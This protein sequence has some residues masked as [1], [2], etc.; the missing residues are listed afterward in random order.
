MIIAKGSTVIYQLSKR[1]KQ[2]VGKIMDFD[3]FGGKL[4]Y[5]LYRKTKGR[6]L[7]A[8]TLAEAW[9]NPNGLYVEESRWVFV[10]WIKAERIIKVL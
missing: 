8:P 6:F 3:H 1:A 2:R 5:K 4:R 9:D 10:Q 7:S